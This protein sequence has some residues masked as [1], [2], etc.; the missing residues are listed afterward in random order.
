M[1]N[2]LSMKARFLYFLYIALFRFTPEDYRPYALF[3]SSIASQSGGRL[4]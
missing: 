1:R 2:Q 3:F 4:W